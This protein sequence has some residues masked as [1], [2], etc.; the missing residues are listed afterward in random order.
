ML[1]ISD[2]YTNAIQAMGRT[3]RIT[4][5]VVLDDGSVIELDDSNIEDGTTSVTWDCVSGE[6]IEFGSAIISQ[7][8]ISIRSDVSRYAFYGAKISLSY[9]I[10]TANLEWACVPLGIFTVSEAER[11]SSLVKIT[12]YDNLLLMDKNC[13]SKVFFGTAYKIFFELCADCGVKLATTESEFAAFPNGTEEI[14]ID[15]TSGCTTY[16]DCAK[17]V[18]QMIGAFVVADRNGAIAI[19]QYH[20]DVDDTLPVKRR[21]STTLSDYICKY[22]GIH[23]SASSGT[24]SALDPYGS[25]DLE[26]TLSD[27]PAW[28]Y[29]VR[30][31][32]QARAESLLA[33]LMLISYTPGKL[34]VISNPALE[35]G[36]LLAVE[37][38]DGTF[39]LLVTGIS[40]KYHGKMEIDSVGVNPYLKSKSERKS[41]A[42]RELQSQTESN[43]LTFYSFTNFSKVVSSSSEERSISQVTFATESSTTAIFIAQLPMHI[44]CDDTV[45]TNIAQNEKVVSITD[46]EG[47]EASILDESGN[48]LVLKVID[49]DTT[50]T[51]THGFVDILISYYLNGEIVDYNVEARCHYGRNVFTLFYPFDSLQSGAILNFEIK[52]SIS[53]GS[54]TATIS[55]RAFRAIV[56]GQ[57]L[58]GGG[59]WDGTLL[60]NETLPD[61]PIEDLDGVA[62]SEEVEINAPQMKRNTY[63]QVIPQT[64]FEEFVSNQII[65][66]VGASIVVTQSTIPIDSSEF[67]Y[68]D[69]YSIIDNEGV[70]PRMQW[71]YKCNEQNIDSG[72]MTAVTAKTDDLV[73]VTEVTVSG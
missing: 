56:Y 48:P 13:G 28:D 49:T 14:Q 73:E 60:L 66:R 57:G 50:R 44:E 27:A 61:Y 65:E 24:Y 33:Y 23:I 62:I 47:N 71:E 36:D 58:A 25:D 2:E 4:G 7:L 3:D 6:E 19:R 22:S 52:I 12:A 29:G 10:Q 72:R 35:C 68:D 38:S 21:Y 16:R 5:T 11:K 17:A 41:A 39:N 67:D 30:E 69:R 59:K 34:S 45:T 18:A 32:L 40:W 9:G 37:T 63:K 53:G 8:D 46:S 15:E 1:R 51:V 54:G 42:Q 31:T 55:P 43:K 26:L 64:Q 70:T 20:T